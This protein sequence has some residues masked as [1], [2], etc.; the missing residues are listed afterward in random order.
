MDRARQEPVHPNPKVSRPMDLVGADEVVS[1]MAVLIG[2][3]FAISEVRRHRTQKVRE[4]A[5]ELVKSYQTVDFAVAITRL[6]DLP[7]GL[8]KE[9][10][11]NYL[12]QDMKFISLLMT[13]WESLGIL[14]FRQEVTLDL[15]DDFYSGPIVL[16]WR[17]LRRYV[18]E[19]RR[20]GGR[21]T[22]FE[23]FQW[24]AER[25]AD[26]ETQLE[27]IPAHIEHRDWQVK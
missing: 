23:W 12:G 7:E 22:Y 15:L 13:T 10:L 16:S 14:M 3:G 11:E 20:I 4:S 21:E 1:A 25:L 18:E 9:Q 19:L 5:L 17:K 8:S 2:F 6:I 24:L 26:Q 27:P